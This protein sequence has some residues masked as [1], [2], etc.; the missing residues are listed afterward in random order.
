M[1]MNHMRQRRHLSSTVRLVWKVGPRTFLLEL[2]TVCL[3]HQKASHHPC[4]MVVEA[5]LTPE[6]GLNFLH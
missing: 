1:P 4:W 6:R 2:T 3:S 5:S